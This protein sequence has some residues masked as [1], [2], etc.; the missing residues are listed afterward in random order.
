MK[1][2]YEIKT[3]LILVFCLICNIN[4]MAQEDSIKVR[5]M[6]FGAELTSDQQFTHTGKYNFANLLRLHA[7]IPVGKS[8]TVDVGSIST[9]MTSKESIGDDIQTFSNIDAEPVPFALSVCGV[10]WDINDKH[11]LFLGI[12]NMNEDYFSSDVTSFFTNSSCGIFPT[13]AGNFP[14]A[15]YP[16]ASVGAHYRYECPLRNIDEANH[17]ALVVQASLYNGTSHNRFTGRTNVFRFCPKSDGIFAL[18]QAEYQHK[19]SSYFIGA[20]GHYGDVLELGER[21]F[22]S[23]LWAYAEQSITD[24]LSLIAAYS[25]AF[26]SLSLCTDFAGLGGKYTMNRFELG[27][28]SDYARF[29]FGD[30]Y[31]TEISCKAHISSHFYIQPA[32]HLI[33]SPSTDIDER[34]VFTAAGMVRFGLS[35]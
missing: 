32:V 23:T 26:T 25:H 1:T 8:L 15:N 28:F 27:L 4:A 14:I 33:V 13:I 10:N 18:A 29:M 35:F 24:N 22:A 2:N 7:S 9:Y 3:L 16:F 5:K 6:E 31:A 12:R 17:D 20:C 30:E 19:G 21:K 34:N 11:S